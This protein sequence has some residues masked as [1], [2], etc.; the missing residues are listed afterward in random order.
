MGLRLLIKGFDFFFSNNILGGTT[1][2]SKVLEFLTVK[3]F[4]VKKK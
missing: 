3:I 4:F 1:L 2:P